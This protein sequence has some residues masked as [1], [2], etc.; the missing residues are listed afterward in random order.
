MANTLRS[1]SSF[2]TPVRFPGLLAAV[3]FLAPLLGL[4]VLWEVIVRFF[5]VSPRTFPSVEA[6]ARA[7]WDMFRDGSLVRHVAG[8]DILDRRPRAFSPVPSRI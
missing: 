6:V 7:S 1:D 5:E 8:W 4:M 2:G 3:T